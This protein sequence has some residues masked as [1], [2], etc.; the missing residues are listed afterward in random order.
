[1]IG[2]VTYAFIRS[3]L[4]AA[5]KPFGFNELFTLTVSAE[6]SWKGIVSALLNAADSHPPLFYVIEHIS[7]GLVRNQEIAYRLPSILAIVFTLTCMFIYGKR[8]SGEIVGFLCA[9]FLLMTAVF[10]GS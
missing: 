10:Q 5:G 6:G 1:M 9:V 7:S 8:Q 3:V 2:L 4:A